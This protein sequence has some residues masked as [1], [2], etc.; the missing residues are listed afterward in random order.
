MMMVLVVTCHRWTYD[1]VNVINANTY[2]VTQKRPLHPCV[3]SMSSPWLCV[4]FAKLV[5]GVIALGVWTVRDSERVV[6]W[7]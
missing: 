2:L 1:V 6:A 4:A 5:G 7:V 3:L